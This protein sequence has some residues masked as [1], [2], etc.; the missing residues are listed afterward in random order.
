MRSNARSIERLVKGAFRGRTTRIEPP[1]SG[2]NLV[3]DYNKEV[4][5]IRHSQYNLST[6]FIKQFPTSYE[7]EIVIRA[8]RA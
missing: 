6:F 7:L 4:V 1:S 3:T 2:N 8:E 5:F